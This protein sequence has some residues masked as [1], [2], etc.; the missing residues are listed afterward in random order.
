MNQPSQDHGAARTILGRW[1]H[2]GLAVCITL[3]LL[4]SLCFVLPVGPEISG[5]LV[6][7]NLHKFIGLNGLF[8]LCLYLMW[9]ARGQAK[10]W[11]ELFPWLS[12]DRMARV[13]SEVFA[14]AEWLHMRAVP[15]MVQGLGIVLAGAAFLSGLAM[16]LAVLMPSLAAQDAM[17]AARALHRWAASLLWGYLSL[18]A[19]AVALHMAYGG[20]EMIRPMFQ[21]LDPEPIEAERATDFAPLAPPAM[22]H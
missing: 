12:R 11:G 20:Y 19:G 15:S 16:V 7:F 10:P 22:T 21:L 2:L 17:A 13:A 14:P 4:L 3:C 8:I 6:A 5:A 18:H 9:T 1:L